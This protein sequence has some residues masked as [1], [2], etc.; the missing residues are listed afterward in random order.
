MSRELRKALDLSPEE[1]TSNLPIVSQQIEDDF[2]FVRKSSYELIGKA[3]EVFED[4]IDIARQSQ[5]PRAYEVLNAMMRNISEMHKDLLDHQKKK[6]DLTGI[7]APT[8]VNNN[9][10]VGTTSD[11]NKFIENM[12]KKE[13]DDTGE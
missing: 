13:N 2:D 10:Y 7:Q 1:E 11:L 8:T 12:N 5:Q 3:N 4:M 9:L 6:Q